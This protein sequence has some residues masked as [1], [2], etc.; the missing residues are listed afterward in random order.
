MALHYVR[1][2]DMVQV[3]I[4]MDDNGAVSMNSNTNNRVL[5]YGLMEIAKESM[6]KQQVKEGDNLVQP[7]PL[8]IQ[9]G[10]N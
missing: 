3:I 1:D 8:G 2:F 4:Q 7:A 5:I 6:I 9:F 10:K